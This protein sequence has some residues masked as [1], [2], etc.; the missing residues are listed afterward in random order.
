MK[1]AVPR[2]VR[3]GERRVA[4]VPESCKK[5]IGKGIEVAVEGGAGERSFLAD[6]AYRQVGVEIGGDTGAMLSTQ[7]I[8]S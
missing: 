3:P 7:P 6:D 2:E 4:L 8:S 1:I 5:L